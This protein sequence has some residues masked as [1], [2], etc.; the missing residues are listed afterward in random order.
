MVCIMR[1]LSSAATLLLSTMS[2]YFKGM[3]L[4]SSQRTLLA[5]DSTVLQAQMGCL[6]HYVNAVHLAWHWTGLRAAMCDMLRAEDAW[7]T[8]YLPGTFRPVQ[9]LCELLW[10][11]DEACPLKMYCGGDHFS[12]LG[13]VKADRI[14]GS[15]VVLGAHALNLGWALCTSKSQSTAE[16]RTGAGTLVHYNSLFSS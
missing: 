14:T 7:R 2:C 15:G 13:R 5:A 9:H 11:E 12:V 1:V 6:A 10:R 4:R 16:N 3:S 8:G